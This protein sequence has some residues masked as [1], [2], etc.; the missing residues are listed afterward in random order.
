MSRTAV[1]ILIGAA[2][3]FSVP[4]FA[5]DGVVLINQATVMATGGFPYKITQPGSYKLSGNLVVPADVDGIDILTDNVAI[6]LNGFT[7]SGPVTCT[8]YSAGID[9]GAYVLAVG[10]NGFTGFIHSVNNVTVRNGTVVGFYIGVDVHG[11]DE[12]VEDIH[13][14]GNQTSGISVEGGVVRRNGASLNGLYGIDASRSTVTENI[15]NFNGQFGLNIFHGVFGSNTFESNGVNGTQVSNI[16]G[17]VSQN[18]NDC[19]GS[20]C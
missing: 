11:I 13:A 17:G 12:L 16:G 3:L 6:D 4:A 8:G 18:N 5:I 20:V 10:I 1:A 7:V 14:T 19:Q 15:A 9:C 2:L